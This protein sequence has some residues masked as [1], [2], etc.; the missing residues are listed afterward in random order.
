MQPLNEHCI[1]Q[2]QWVTESRS[3]L[4][5]YLETLAPGMLLR[6]IP[7]FSNGGSIRN[8]L[9]HVANVYQH[10]A[11]IIAL[12]KT[13][14][15]AVCEDFTDIPQMRALYHAIDPLINE[16]LQQEA[17]TTTQVSFSLNKEQRTTSLFRIFTHVIT[18]ECH[19][20]GQILTISRLLGYTPVDTDIIH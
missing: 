6:A 1:L 8:L 17:L 15:Y 13:I 14:T 3:R 16:L 19:H 20:K 7:S 2:Y 18:H 12:N 5:H 4:L 9:V 10:W 11:G